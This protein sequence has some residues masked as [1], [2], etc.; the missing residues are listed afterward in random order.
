MSAGRVSRR[1]AFVDRD[2]VVNALVPDPVSGDGESPLDPAD[3]RLLPGAAAALR[4]LRSAGFVLVGVSNQPAAAKAKISVSGVEA[5]QQR[6]L[7]LLEADGTW[8][9][10]FR[11]CLH[12]PEGIV[13]ELSRSCRCRKPAPGMLLDAADQL[14]IVLER[15][16][17]IGDID[18]DV[19]AGR[20]AGCR[21]VLVEHPGSAHK[22]GNVTSDVSVGDLTA[23]AAAILDQEPL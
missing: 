12:H 5:V 16:W 8:F 14:G 15:S 4:K 11:L 22:R 6:V 20:A 9:D 18:T 2:G 10:A 17:M 23:A 13:P 19:E 1:A 3:V 7:E 21:T